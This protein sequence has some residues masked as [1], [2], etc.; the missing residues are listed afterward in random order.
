MKLSEKIRVLGTI[1]GT[2]Y[3]VEEEIAMAEALEERVAQLEAE[4]ERLQAEALY[5][6]G[7]IT[8]VWLNVNALTAEQIKALSREILT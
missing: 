1:G 4:I 6:D 8:D 5:Y 3:G 2:D 7:D